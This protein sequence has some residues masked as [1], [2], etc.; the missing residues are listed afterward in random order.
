MK[1]FLLSLLSLCCAV[2]NAQVKA[3][4]TAEEAMT[5]YYKQGFDT[6]EEA[7]T[8]TY[9]QTNENY[10]WTLLEQPTVTGLKPFSSIDPSSKL[11]LAIRYDD[12]NRQDET[13]TSPEIEIKPGSVCEFY[14]C[15][16]G[17]FLVF[18]KWTLSVTDVSDNKTTVLL[19]AF[20]WAQDNNYTGPNWVKFSLDLSEYTGKTVKF[21]FNYNGIGG[22]DALFDGFSI[23]Q[24]D[25]SAD[26]SVTINE[27]E[28]V[29]FVNQTA[30][31]EAYEWSFPGGTPATSADANPVVTYAKAGT[32]D[33]T[34]TATGDGGK[35]VA[36]RKAYVKV[37]AAAPK[38]LIGTPSDGYLSPWVACFVPLN[39]PVQFTDKS[40]GMPTSW[41]WQ[42][43]GT[44][45]T[46]S[47]E[48]NPTVTYI[49][50]GL[51]GVSLQVINE[52]GIDNDALVN[53]IQA[54]GSQYV[55]NIAPEDNDKLDVVSLSW[56]GYYAGTNWLGMEKFAE[57]YNKPLAPA[58]VD[59]VAVYLGKADVVTPDADITL[60]VNKVGDDGMPGEEL[61]SATMKASELVYDATS[62]KATVF[63]FDKPVAVNDK[64]FVTI[65]GFPN[66]T[67]ENTYAT[68]GIAILT[69][70]RSRAEES[71]TY[72]YLEEEDENYQPTGNYKWYK[73][74]DDPVSMAVAPCI[75]YGDGTTGIVLPG[76]GTD[77]RGISFDGR[78]IILATPADK[79]AVYSAGGS[80]VYSA[81]NTQLSVSLPQ[82]SSGLY[83][84]KAYTGKNVSVLKFA[85]R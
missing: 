70:R 5:T 33:V 47:T 43:Q 28:A 3:A 39:V 69:L 63:K 1:T 78:N 14:S 82:L 84:V 32:Y 29:H 21:S 4:F 42:F 61:A 35:A 68:D 71:T 58:T 73:N 54:G 45:I 48:Q 50:K 66:N 85:K 40:A 80:L 17:G 77:G 44:D 30:G 8:W 23:K 18:A 12:K 81:A 59:S 10:T 64:F 24:N 16:S 62:V 9:K 27:G 79:L 11:S 46:S 15:F 38:A 76:A 65:G 25:T 57:L 52:A 22:E 19:D 41:K 34:L 74:S 31:A 51:Y 75:N 36:E 2:A 37:Q 56:Y 60:T 49:Q 7:A 6:K 20:K 67:D 26:A 72:H 53:A 13:A 55:W 83:I